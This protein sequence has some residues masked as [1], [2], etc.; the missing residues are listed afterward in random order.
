MTSASTTTTQVCCR[1]PMS[2]IEVTS[3]GTTLVLHSCAKCGRH[4]WER[5]G[6]V[7]DKA[8]LLAGVQTFLE[9]P[10]VRAPRAKKG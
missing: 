1:R 8:E 5:D 10:R 2:A 4:R 7:A 3:R 9:Q 6:Q